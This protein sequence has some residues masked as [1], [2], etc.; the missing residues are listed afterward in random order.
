MKSKV[1]SDILKDILIPV[2]VLVVAI[3]I[4]Q[5]SAWITSSD[6]TPLSTASAMI[7]V[8]GE[9]AFWKG[10]GGTFLR[11]LIA[12]SISFLLAFV[13]AVVSAWYD[14]VNR[15]LAPVITV[16]RSLPTM[17]VVLI[18]ILTVS[19]DMTT[20]LVGMLVLFPTF[21]SALL[22]VSKSVSK[23]LVEISLVCGANRLQRLRYVYLPSMMPAVTENGISGLSL[24]IKLIVSAEVLSQTARS[25]GMMMQS[26]KAYLEIDRLIALTLI[27]VIVC[28]IID[29]IGKTSLYFFQKKNL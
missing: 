15:I 5:A 8:L 4:W 11:A 25:I 27:V 19:A 22:P 9:G 2:G 10:L 21:Y 14:I 6:A 23:D 12:F 24:S 16:L 7:N 13:L 3:F 17:A 28:L 1:K 26:A 18:F 20:V 29:A